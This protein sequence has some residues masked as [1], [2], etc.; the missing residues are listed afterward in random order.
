MNRRYTPSPNFIL[1]LIVVLTFW[2]IAWM[3]L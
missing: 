3:L 1:T 2:A